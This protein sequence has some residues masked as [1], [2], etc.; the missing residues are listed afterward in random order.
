MTNLELLDSEIT[1][2]KSEVKSFFDATAEEYRP[3]ANYIFDLVYD[4]EKLVNLRKKISILFDLPE[5][6]KL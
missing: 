2:L 5:G 6:V 4:L 1:R 3:E